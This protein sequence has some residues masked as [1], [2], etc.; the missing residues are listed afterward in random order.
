MKKIKDLYYGIWLDLILGLQKNKQ[1][2]KTNKWFFLFFMSFLF[3]MHYFPYLMFLPK[4]INFISLFLDITFFENSVLDRISHG[5]IIFL[6]PGLI[7]HY[8]LIYHKKRYIVLA[9][10]YKFR[11]GK[12]FIRYVTISVILFCIPYLIILIIKLITDN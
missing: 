5:L 10:K 8:I 1:T 12:L 6:F 7:L 3:G 4:S 9:D 11:N 2:W